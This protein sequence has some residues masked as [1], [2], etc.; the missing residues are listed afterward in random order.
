LDIR[1]RQ[2]GIEYFLKALSTGEYSAAQRLEP[3]LATDVS[4]ETNSQPGV[5]P[6]GRE[7]FNGRDEVLARVTGDWPVVPEYRRLGWSDPVAD[8]DA[9]RVVSSGTVA[10]RFHFNDVDEISDIRLDGGWL[11]GAVPTLDT[12]GVVTEIPLSVKGLI[13]SAL[14]NQTPLVVSYVDDDGIQHSTFRGS[15]SVIGP[16]QLGI[17]LRDASGGLVR[18]LGS[19][20]HLTFVY[21]D[22]RN[23]NMV[24]IAGTGHVDA[25][26]EVRR[27]VYEL[28]AER[29]QFHDLGRRGVAVVVE[30]TDL[31]AFSSGVVKRFGPGGVFRLP[32]P[33]DQ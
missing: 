31:L 15:V 5:P 16:R 25:D 24:T 10:L 21:S 23:T 8:G 17:W 14:I 6:V 18:S 13:N 29:E 33:K 9:L 32:E 12:G 7:T 11:T 28:S 30:V 3:L 26:P 2:L 4:Y 1:R 22:M 19:H 27:K 20:P